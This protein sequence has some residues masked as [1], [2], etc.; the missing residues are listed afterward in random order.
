MQL[1]VVQH[2]LLRFLSVPYR[3]L[4]SPLF[5]LHL[6]LSVISFSSRTSNNLLLCLRK[7][8]LTSSIHIPTA[9]TPITTQASKCTLAE[10]MSPHHNSCFAG[11]QNNGNHGS[12]KDSPLLALPFGVPPNEHLV[13]HNGIWFG[14]L[15]K[16]WWGY[17]GLPSL[18][19]VEQQAELKTLQ[20]LRD[21]D[22]ETPGFPACLY[23]S[24]TPSSRDVCCPSCCHDRLC[25]SDLKITTHELVFRDPENNRTHKRRVSRHSSPVLLTHLYRVAR[26]TCC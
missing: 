20:H 5:H 18:E 25:G 22:G 8:S 17:F 26:L 24:S 19:K 4:S 7:I 23:S 21:P 14:Y 6:T 12:R 3:T 15:D 1:S 11:P 9:I 10:N 16:P 13:K 2:P